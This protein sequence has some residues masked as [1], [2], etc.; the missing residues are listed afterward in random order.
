MAILKWGSAAADR[1]VRAFARG[2]QR[3]PGSHIG[4]ALSAVILR[5]WPTKM[6]LI[7]KSFFGAQRLALQP[8]DIGVV[9][10]TVQESIGDGGVPNG[11]VPLRDGILAG[12]QRGAAADPVIDHFKQ[13]A[14]LLALGCGQAEVINLCG[15]PH[16]STRS[17]MP[18]PNP[19]K[20][21]Y[22]SPCCK[23]ATS[24]A[25]PSSPPTWV[26]ANGLP[27]SRTPSDRRLDRPAC[28]FFPSLTTPCI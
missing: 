5:Q 25:Q 20:S 18:R 8:R 9:D 23:S 1:A 21:V 17:D 13:V 12:Q 2:L 19:P 16:K 15:D 26:L 22:S 4:V 28:R 24:S 3:A 11:I 6:L 10:Q 7:R 14:V 27:F